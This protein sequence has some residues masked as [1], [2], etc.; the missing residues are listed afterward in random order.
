M[1][2][3]D[4]PVFILCGGLGTRLREWTEF[5]PKPMVP[6]GER[7]ILWHIM[8]HYNRFGFRRFVL[9]M[10]YKSEVIREYFLNYYAMN[11]DVTV[12]LGTNGLRVHRRE[13]TLDWEVTLAYTG[14]KTMTGARI[15]R[16][17]ALYL[18]GAEHFAVTYGDGVTDADLA[19]ELRYHL[20]HDRLGTVLGINPPSRFGE[21]R[22][23]GEELE[24]FEEKPGLHGVWING[25]FFLFRRGFLPRLSPGEDCVL[26]Q[27]ALSGLARDGQLKVFT[28]GGFWACM[29]TLRDHEHL[30]DLWNTGRAPWRRPDIA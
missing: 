30:N 11:A 16:A 24:S 2:P 5:R 29:D 27:E 23:K 9:C 10:G 25:G 18:N 20:A 26:E 4:I 15:A 8:N 22:M 28:H 21:L 19:A 6:I 1:T 17:A 3:A 13:H 7:P 14:E 12:D